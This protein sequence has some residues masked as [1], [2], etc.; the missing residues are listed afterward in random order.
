R[1]EPVR[2]KR[3]QQLAQ[4]ERLYQRR[5]ADAL[6]EQG[7]TLTDPARIDVRGELV[8][9][10]DV[11]ID[12][13]CVF[14]GRVA[15]GDG[16]RIGPYSVLR[17]CVVG[18]GTEVLGHCYLE[19]ATI[20]AHARIGPFA[21]MRPTVKLD[22]E[23]H[24]GNFVEV[25]N[26]SMGHGSKANHLAYVGDTTAGSRVNIGA[27]TIVANYDGVNKHP[28]TIGDDVHTGSN[29]VLVAPIAVGDGAPIGAGST[30]SK[31]PPA[32]KLTVARA[33]QT[34]IEGWK[35]PGKEPG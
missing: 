25:K 21:R 11:S 9:G 23:V 30:T 27:G 32:G 24:I 15:L 1:T 31:K 16:V 20:G 13:D 26:S 2:C 8:C 7:V 29:S 4:L 12:I 14:E 34:T 33:K 28:T 17:D 22:D 6:L 18:I 5:R 19:G 10:A 3:K 35:R